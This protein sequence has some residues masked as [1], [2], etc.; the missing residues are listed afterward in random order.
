MLISFRHAELNITC[1]LYQLL[2]LELL[3]LAGGESFNAYFN[4]LCFQLLGDIYDN[5]KLLDVDQLSDF[6]WSKVTVS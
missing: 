6:T 4:L 3:F 2:F 1:Q 5:T